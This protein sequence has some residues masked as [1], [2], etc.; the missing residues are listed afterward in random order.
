MLILHG[1]RDSIVNIKYSHQAQ[2]SYKNATLHIM[3]NGK[4][5]FKGKMDTKAIELIKDFARR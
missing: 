1:T 3:E 5:G 2:K 4:H